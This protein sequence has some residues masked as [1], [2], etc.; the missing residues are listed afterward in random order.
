MTPAEFENRLAKISQVADAALTATQPAMVDIAVR[1]VRRGIEQSIDVDGRPFAPLKH[2]RPTGGSKPLNASGA[3][4]QSTQATV[5][6]GEL[7]IS[8]TG[9]GATILLNGG[10]ITP[11]KA[12]NL[13]I[14]LTAAALQ[15]GSPRNYPG[16]LFYLRGKSGKGV[17]AEKSGNHGQVKAQYVLV[18]SVTIPERKYLGLSDQSLGEIIDVYEEKAIEQVMKA[19]E[20]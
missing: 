15:A 14:P 7:V 1:G 5:T 3:L 13:A 9:P 18:K 19:L 4:G 16:Q 8:A 10:T 17:L 6:D 12:K 11:T 2:P 20:S